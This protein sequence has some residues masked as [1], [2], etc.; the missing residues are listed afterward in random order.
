M[1]KGKICETMPI[2]EHSMAEAELMEQRLAFWSGNAP[3]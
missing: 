1:A 3:A 2:K